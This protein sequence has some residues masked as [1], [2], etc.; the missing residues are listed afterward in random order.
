MNFI[1]INLIGVSLQQY[2]AYSETLYTLLIFKFKIIKSYTT[3]LKADSTDRQ[4]HHTIRHTHRKK[5]LFTF[6]LYDKSWHSKFR[7]EKFAGDFSSE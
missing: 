1:S 4:R 2:I 6:I 5:K 7:I 3:P